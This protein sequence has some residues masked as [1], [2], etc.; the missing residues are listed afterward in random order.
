MRANSHSVLPAVQTRPRL[1]GALVAFVVGKALGAAV[2]LGLIGLMYDLASSPAF[3]TTR[4]TVAGN[5]LLATAEVESLATA[6]EGNAFWLRRVEIASRLR[7]LP[8]VERAE[9]ALTL[10]NQVAVRV[11]ER[12]PV[13]IWVTGE[14]PF[15]VDREGVVLSTLAAPRPLSIL[16]DASNPTLSP[17]Q[18]VDADAVRT[19]AQ[20]EGMLTERFGPQERQFQYAPDT[21]VQV[22]QAVGPRLMIGSGEH[23]AWKIASI[24]SVVRHLESSRT[25]AELIDV[26]FGDRPYF[27]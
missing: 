18:R 6:N 25:S 27:R 2:L 15:L 17:G 3:N 7:Q 21:G 13:A 16:R 5:Q 24:E 4:V 26:R 19:A 9:V 23:L 20:L 11:K 10:P 14:T 1:T 22:I 12:E 8:P